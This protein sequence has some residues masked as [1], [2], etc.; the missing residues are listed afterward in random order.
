MR[1]KI[2]EIINLKKHIRYVDETTQIWQKKDVLPEMQFLVDKIKD[3]KF[4]GIV[5]YPLA[6]MWDPIQRPHHFLRALA[7]KG[8]LCFFCE[9]NDSE[10]YI[11]KE[12]YDN[13]FL[14]NGEEK[15]IPLLKD[16]KIIFLI[17]YFLQ[18]TYC[19]NYENKFIWFDLLDRLD[20]MASYNCVSKK[21][22]KKLIKA[23]DI[24]TYSS[25]NLAF[26]IKNRNDNI[27]LPNAANIEDFVISKQYIPNDL[28]PIIKYKKPI[29][30]YY[31]AIESWFDFNLIS[32]LD[33]T[34]KY[35]I[36]LIG[37]TN[38]NINQQSYNFNNVYFL[39]PK[40]FADLKYYANNFKVAMIPFIISDLT[41]AVSPVKFFE[42]MALNLP[43]I[44]TGI[45]EMNQYDT[46]ILRIVN[47][48]NIINEVDD[49]LLLKKSVIKKE[50]DIIA[51]K[52]TWLKRIEKV[53]GK[54]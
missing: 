26:Y 29:I 20:F 49:L 45:Y 30:G 33:K 44:S 1:N 5:V 46:P 18:Y 2:R 12:M 15:L 50:T 32:I 19:L 4:K 21:I 23:A 10:K 17:T 34:N 27:L 7:E 14:I 13:V 51:K 16:E 37:K 6:V 3:S 38:E 43:V 28:Q 40:P 22:Y 48:N 47:E 35:S 24:V 41:N 36:V 9:A 8:Y 39:G 54:F 31:G 53:E 11:V 42:Y 52:N 25:E